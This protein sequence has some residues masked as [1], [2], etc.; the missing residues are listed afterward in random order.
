MPAGDRLSL[1]AAVLQAVG[2]EGGL[3]ET[4]AGAFFPPVLLTILIFT[5]H[6]V[7][8]KGRKTHRPKPM[9]SK[10]CAASLLSTI[11]FSDCD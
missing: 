5:W 10:L 1:F 11:I 2:L 8:D 9:T 6:H 3:E 4:G 7:E